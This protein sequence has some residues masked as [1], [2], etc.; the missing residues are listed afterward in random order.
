MAKPVMHAPAFYVNMEN[1]FFRDNSQLDVNVRVLFMVNT[2]Q[3]NSRRKR[4]ENINIAAFFKQY[5]LL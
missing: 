5:L 4:L 3:C 1:N 2:S